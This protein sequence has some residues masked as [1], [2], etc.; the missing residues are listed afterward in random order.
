MAAKLQCEICGGKLIGRPG[1]IFECDSCGMEYDTAWAKEKIQ[2]ITGTVK[3]EG[4]VQVQGSV[5]IENPVSI[6]ESSKIDTMLSLGRD[7]LHIHQR[8]KASTYFEGVLVI[9][10]TNAEAYLGKYMANHWIYNRDDVV[11]YLSTD[12]DDLRKS[13]KY[14]T[15]EL[16]TWF[17]NLEKMAE[18]QKRKL[19][20]KK[21]LDEEKKQKPV[22]Y[23]KYLQNVLNGNREMVEKA[24]EFFASNSDFASCKEAE[25]LCREK[26]PHSDICCELENKIQSCKD[27]LVTHQ[28]IMTQYNKNLSELGFFGARE[29][30]AELRDKIRR[31]NDICSELEKRVDQYQEELSSIQDVA[32]INRDIHALI[33][34]SQIDQLK[35]GSKIELG[36]Y[37]ADNA[38]SKTPIVWLP[39]TKMTHN[40]TTYV[41]LISDRILDARTRGSAA[42]KWNNSGFQSWL[43]NDFRNEAFSEIEQTIIKDIRLLNEKIELDYIGSTRI[44]FKFNMQ[45]L[46]TKYAEKRGVRRGIWVKIYNYGGKSDFEA[47][48]ANGEDMDI[49]KVQESMVGVRPVIE[50]A[51]NKEI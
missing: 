48:D 1:G 26:L 51:F 31:E 49:S 27:E 5:K 4:T 9:D 17:S 23:Q 35:S 39:C 36:R 28:Q 14:A 13:R 40:G 30:K 15:G 37:Y 25:R 16:K 21:V 11:N 29:E 10:P 50:I 19:E 42:G 33:L 41:T 44:R 22:N 43:Q 18:Q 2:E 8:D 3:V 6:D 45:T 32:M 46:P 24:I 34:Q 20:E 12:D 7:A 47:V 38:K